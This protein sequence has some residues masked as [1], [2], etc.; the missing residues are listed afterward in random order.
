MAGTSPAMTE[1]ILY[2]RKLLLQLDQ[3][4]PLIGDD[5]FHRFARAEPAD[6]VDL[7]EFLTQAGARRPFHLEQVACE[8]RQVEIALEGEAMHGLAALLPDR[9]QRLEWPFR[10]QSGFL[11]ELAKRTGQE[12][13]RPH[14]AFGDGP[15]ASV[16]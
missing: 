10:G 16:L 1:Q 5:L 13:V 2:F 6:P 8:F 15:G 7:G 14:Q 11:P 3:E 4:R 12:I 9:L